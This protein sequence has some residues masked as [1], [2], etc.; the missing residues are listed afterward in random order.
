MLQAVG[1]V[2]RREG[3]KGVAV[4]VD[5]RYADG[6]YRELFPKH[7]ENVQYAGNA[8]SLAEIMRRFW[9]KPDECK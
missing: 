5:D 6:K 9:E 3:D 4:L 7:W 2:I 8:R 1:R